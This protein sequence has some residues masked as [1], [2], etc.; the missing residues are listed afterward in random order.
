MET[1]GTGPFYEIAIINSL[2]KKL[3]QVTL[4]EL[5]K[6]IYFHEKFL[7][8]VVIAD[9]QHFQ[10]PTSKLPELAK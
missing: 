9:R 2:T 8:G 3:V 10:R 5:V 6:T 4:D 7:R 1:G